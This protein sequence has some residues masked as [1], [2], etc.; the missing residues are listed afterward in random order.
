MNKKFIS[1]LKVNHTS[2][3]N[4]LV[5][6]QLLVRTISKLD[7]LR[8]VICRITNKTYFG[9][10]L[11]AG[12]TWEERKPYMESLVRREM[13]K[14]SKGDFKILEV[15]S[16]AGDSAIT[17]ADA[18]KSEGGKGEIVCVDPWIPYFKLGKDM[19]NKAPL[20]MEEALK[21]DRIFQLFLHNIKSANVFSMITPMKGLSDK[22]L[23]LLREEVFNLAFID[24]SHYYSN[25][26]NDF[27]NA[28]K[29]ICKGGILCG[30][31]LELQSHEI[32][33]EFAEANMEVDMILDPKTGKEYHPG[34]SLAVRDFFKG[35]V[36]SSKGFWAMRKTR[37]GWKTVD[38]ICGTAPESTLN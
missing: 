12:Q 31:D 6:S 32:D 9:F 36:S 30:D 13:I 2:L 26:I 18:I 1:Y 33:I 23:L 22:V 16:W 25:V 27:K 38:L 34:V 19:I 5:K 24:G 29:L 21:S 3:F 15:G 17:W 4:K 37:N 7:F 14:G 11:M 20:V 35:P 28:E 8:Y 10:Y